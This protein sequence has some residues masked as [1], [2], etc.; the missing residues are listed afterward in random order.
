MQ[1]WSGWRDATREALIAPMARRRQFRVLHGWR[2]VG[3]GPNCACPPAQRPFRGAAA[4]I[5][6]GCGAGHRGEKHETSSD[7]LPCLGYTDS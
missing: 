2:M 6:A 3:A 4:S 5:Q 7:V 1:G